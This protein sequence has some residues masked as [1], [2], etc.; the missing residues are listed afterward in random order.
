MLQEKVKHIGE[1]FPK[2]LGDEVMIGKII[3][4][5]III[6]LIVLL[7]AIAFKVAFGIFIF[8]LIVEA[9]L[10]GIFGR[11]NSLLMIRM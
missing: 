1:Y 4:F 3:M 7:L 5:V 11:D 2:I 9:I 10:K 6:F 8:S